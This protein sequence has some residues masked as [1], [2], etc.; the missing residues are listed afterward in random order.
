[1]PDGRLVELV[2]LLDR[3]SYSGDCYRHQGPGHPPL[4]AEGARIHGGRWNPKE[5]FPVLYL[6]RTE[7]TAAA[8]FFR[9][10]ETRPRSICI[11]SSSP[12]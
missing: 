5:S 12:L 1:M 2:D 11:A 7:S 9:L 4:N 8:E 6:A 3:G 10:A